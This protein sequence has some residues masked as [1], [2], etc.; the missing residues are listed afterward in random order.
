MICAFEKR[1]TYPDSLSRRLQRQ[2]SESFR[3]GVSVKKASPAGAGGFDR[4]GLKS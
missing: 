3:S 4:R 1:I 2:N